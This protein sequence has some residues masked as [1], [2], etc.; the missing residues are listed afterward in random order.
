MKEALAA[1]EKGR[2]FV[3]PNPTVGCTIVDKD[4]KFLASAGHMKF[5]G[6][7]AEI[8][9]LEKISDK[10]QLQ[11]ATI[12]VTLEPCAHEGKTGSCAK[13]IAQHPFKEL[14][15][16]TLDPNPLV[17][18]KGI[19]IVENAGIGIGHFQ[20]LEE[21]CKKSCEDFL[22]H[23]T[24]EMPFVVVKVASSLDGKIA[25][26]NG[27]SQWITG[28]ETRAH[29]RELRAHYDATMIGAGTFLNDDPLLDFRETFY[30]GKRD[31]RIVILDPRAKG[32][33]FWPQ[34]QLS[35]KHK[36]ENI[37]VLTRKD[38]ME[39]WQNHGIKTLAWNSSPVGWEVAMKSLYKEGIASLFV[40]GGAYAISQLLQFKKVH[41]LYLYQAPKIM[42]YGKSWADYF[43]VKSVADAPQ[44]KKWE[45]EKL[46]HD[47]LLTGWF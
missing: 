27:D 37:F 22:F 15:Y 46:E 24:H 35:K 32:A 8:L 36:K 29:A 42:G 45:I 44:L 20:A 40:E 25:L 2:G 28:P 33:Q 6:P 41:K 4:H 26:T 47:N 10:S 9:A 38:N 43:K 34:S 16:G 23:I 17:T 5:G 13:A 18:G 14:I 12:Y 11:G 39:V 19:L 3:S 7:H 1:A 21:E 31:N 30:E